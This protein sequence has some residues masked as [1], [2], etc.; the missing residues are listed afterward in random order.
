TSGRRVSTTLSFGPMTGTFERPRTRR[1]RPA[2]SRRGR[3]PRASTWAG[4]AHL[5]LWELRQAGIVDLV[6]G[7]ADPDDGAGLV[8]GPP[9][10]AEA[11]RRVN[12]EQDAAQRAEAGALCGGEAVA[13]RRLPGVGGRVH[14]A[15]AGGGNVK[16]PRHDVKGGGQRLPLGLIEQGL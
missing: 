3:Q 16:E 13:M 7:R 8:E 15:G 4:A 10:T 6:V 2:A 12:R 14:Q 1:R 9:D 5:P 11:S